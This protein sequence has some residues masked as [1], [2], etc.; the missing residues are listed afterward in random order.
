MSPIEDDEETD[1]HYRHLAVLLS[2]VG[3]GFIAIMLLLAWFVF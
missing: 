1:E 3:I 2:V